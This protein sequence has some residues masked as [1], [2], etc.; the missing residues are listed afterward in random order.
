MNLFIAGILPD[1]MERRLMAALENDIDLIPALVLGGFGGLR[2]AEFHA[3]RA[4]R[5]PLRWDALI[6]D[7]GILYITGQKI[8]SKPNRSIPLQAV[9]EAWL[10]PF[11]NCSGWQT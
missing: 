2:P 3:E 5:P 11:A 10:R 7:D 6:W 9:A 8:R 4:K 1:E